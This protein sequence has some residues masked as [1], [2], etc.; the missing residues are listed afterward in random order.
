MNSAIFR[1]FSFFAAAAVLAGTLFSSAAGAAPAIS[2]SSVVEN[3]YS[4]L[5]D[6]MKRGE[7]LGFSGRYKKLE[8]VITASFNFP[9]MTRFAVGPAWSNASDEERQQTVSAFSR[10]SVA[11]WASRFTKS[12]GE[13]FEVMGE[14]PS[15]GGGTM[16]ETRLVPKDGE[17]VT[18][19]YLVR[20]NESGEPRIID[21]FLDATIS[22]L[23]TRRSEF[24][25]I[26]RRQG[27]PALSTALEEK[28]RK[29]GL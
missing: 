25:S 26:V 24:S 19:N 9:L 17:P 22:E 23:A 2:A 13:K 20:P 16:V 14:K 6:T 11:M 15:A 18:L 28:S 5:S 29:M 10:F 27:L 21:V 4:Q 12:D 8:P 3:F 7:S 1:R